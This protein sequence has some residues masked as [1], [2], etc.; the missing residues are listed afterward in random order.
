MAQAVLLQ[1]RIGFGHVGWIAQDE[2]KSR[3]WRDGVVPVALQEVQVLQAV[4]AGVLTGDLERLF[5]QV[6]G[7][8]PPMGPFAGHCQGD[9]A[10]AGAKVQDPEFALGGRSCKNFVACL[11]RQ[12]HQQFGLRAGHQGC[13]GDLQLQRPEL[14][15]ARDIGQGFARPSALQ[16]FVK[17]C[18]LCCRQLP[19]RPG[20]EPAQ[21]SAQ[22][23]GEDQA[24]I[25]VPAC[26]A[27][28]F[29]NGGHAAESSA[30]CSAWY[31]WS[32]GSMTWSRLPA[33][34][35]SSL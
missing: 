8:D 12:L 24:G 23:M 30:S 14:L 31:S 29:A 2:V 6:R 26:L 15:F 10:G 19:F 11:Q 34:I 3:V 16:Q 17:A 21:G 33:M 7:S 25:L 4:A 22:D 9:G 28:G 18:E 1:V 20:I 5:A 35:S 27:Q 32:R 13:G